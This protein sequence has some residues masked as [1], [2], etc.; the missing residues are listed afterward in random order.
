MILHKG[1]NISFGR[2]AVGGMKM[3]KGILALIIACMALMIVS[4]FAQGIVV[5]G[6][7]NGDKIVSAEELAAAEKLAQEG[8]LSADELQEIRHIHEKYPI[9]ITDS[10]NRTVTF[11][12]PAER[13]VNLCGY[14]YEPM[15]ILGEEDKVVGAISNAAQIAPWFNDLDMLPVVGTFSEFDYEKIIEQ[16]PD[17]VICYPRYV[18][19]LES[20]LE[21]KNIT[22]VALRFTMPG[23]FERELQALSDITGSQARQE[24]FLKWKEEILNRLKERVDNLEPKEKKRVYIEWSDWPWHT[25]GEGTG[26]DVLVTLA[27]GTNLA[28]DLKMDLPEVDSEWVF[29]QNPQAI[30]FSSSATY[31]PTQLTGYTMNET[32]NAEAFL[33]EAALRSGFKGTDAVNNGLLFIIDETLAE[34]TRNFIGANYLA[35]MLYP[36]RFKDLDPEAIHKEYFEK[37]L[38]VPYKGIWAYPAAS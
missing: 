14:A 28:K 36:E 20:Q 1:Q 37:W 21:G 38:G 4:A 16:N 9:S 26:K 25:G 17:V 33:A 5:P 23:K 3:S 7:S 18:S 32:E 10:A 30:V 29:Q 6:D 11:Y 19:D 31:M 13:I 27:G 8:K 22:V 34:G 35:K 12:Q 15:V 2:E 24:D